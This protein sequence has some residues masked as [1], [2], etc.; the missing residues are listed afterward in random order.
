M[1]N[2]R[3]EGQLVKSPFLGEEEGR[4]GGWRRGLG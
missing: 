4:G 3:G 1:P 2:A